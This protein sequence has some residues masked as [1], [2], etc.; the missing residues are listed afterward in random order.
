MAPQRCHDPFDFY[1]IQMRI[2]QVHISATYQ[3]LFWSD[4]R[5]LKLTVWKLTENIEEQ[6][7]NAHMSHK[8]LW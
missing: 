3:I 7:G 2:Y 6:D 4:L 1:E 5:E 8:M